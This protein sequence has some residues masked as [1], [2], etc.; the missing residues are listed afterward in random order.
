MPPTVPQRHLD[1]TPAKCITRRRTCLGRLVIVAKLLNDM[2]LDWAGRVFL[3][4]IH[5]GI[6]ATLVSLIA[7]LRQ[8]Q[9]YA[10]YYDFQQGLLAKVIEVQAHRLACRRVARRLRA[11]ERLPSDAPE[12]RSVG[13]VHDA[14]TWELE[15]DVCERV[16]RQLRSVADAL[17][18]RVFNYDRRVIV[19]LSRNDS[20]GLMVGK[21]GLERERQFVTEAWRDG[22]SFV[23][24]HDLT[25]CLR[26]GDATE[27]KS[28][29]KGWEAYLHEV[30][31]DPTRRKSTQA[32]RRRLAEAAIRDS[33]PLPGDPDARFVEI[34]V[35]YRTHLP[36]LRDAFQI[37]AVRGL[38][39]MKVP[40][41]RV[42][43]AADMRKGY[44]LWPEEE[45]LE[46]TGQAHE[47]VLRRANL[48]DVGNRVFYGSDD[49]TARSSIQPPWAI[50]PLPPVMCVNLITDMAV[51]IVTVS[52]E[53]LL[54]ALRSAGLGAEWVLP[55]G[56]TVE[57]GQ[58]ILRAYKGYR[59]IE[60][61]PSDMQRFA[62]EL[63][64][65]SVWVE[66]V[67]TLLSQEDGSGQHPWPD[68]G[69]EWK[70]WA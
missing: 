18:W 1:T 59:G 14:A 38:A 41:G 16:D 21:A 67:K 64:D 49:R 26:I 47:R 25:T 37:A 70:V 53:P 11:G 40:G 60:M 24:L 22:G 36:M 23:L 2:P 5:Q 20:A 45:F 42:M 58:V 33:G 39:D 52:S 46:R 43:I 62:L 65:L 7:D 69:N 13:D 50:Y 28:V 61:K 54:E 56:Q 34:G 30:K 44:E 31:T 17:A 15:M 68:Y 3:H 35:R 19:A 51:Y 9:E 66:T 48:L 63:E 27:F 4:P 29:G 6:P 12:L 10:D 55:P 32:R 57:A 8:C